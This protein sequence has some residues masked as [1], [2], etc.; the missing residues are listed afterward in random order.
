MTLSKEEEFQEAISKLSDEE[1]AALV[2]ETNEAMGSYKFVPNEGP[3]SDAYFSKADVTLFGGNPGGGKSALI[4]G[5]ANNE[6]HRS[7]IVRKNFSDLEGIMDNAKKILGTTKGFVG[8]SRPKYTK[9]DGGVMH[10]AGLA[11]DGGIGGHQGVD[12]DLLCVGR[13]T[14]VLMADGSYVCIE[15][16]SVGDM[17]DTLEGPR[18]I[19]KTFPVR[20]DYGVRVFSSTPA[21]QLQSLDHSLYSSCSGGSW[22]KA[23]S[24]A[25]SASTLYCAFYRLFGQ[26]FGLSPAPL[27]PL[28]VLLIY[29]ARKAEQGLRFLGNACLSQFFSCGE[30]SHQESGF[31]KYYGLRPRRLPPLLSSS[32]RAHQQPPLRSWLQRG[33]SSISLVR[34]VSGAVSVS[35]PQG[36]Q[37]SCLSGSCLC[38]GQPRSYPLP[39]RGLKGSLL[40]LL[41][42]IGV[43]R[44][45]PTYFACDCE[46]RTPKCTRRVGRYVHPYKMDTRPIYKPLVSCV[47]YY[48]PV[49]VIDLFDIEVEDANHYITRGGF[50]NKNCVDEAA[51]VPEDQV[52][53]LMTWLRTDKA[54]QRVRTVLASNPPLDSTGDWLVEYFAPW[55]DERH[56]N[57]AKAGELRYFLPAEDGVG[58]R[59]CDKDEIAMVHGI[60]VRPQSRTYIPSKFTDNPYYDPEEYAKQLAGMPDSYKEIL[61][62][63]NFMLNREDQDRQVIPTSWVR[64]ANARWT[65]AGRQKPM[66]IIAADVAGGGKDDNV[67]ARLHGQW[68][69]ELE[70]KSGKKLPESSDVAGFIISKRKNKAAIAIDMG[71]GYGSGPKLALSDSGASIL[72]YKGVKGTFGKNRDKSLGFTNVRSEAYWALRE[73]LDP[74]N[75]DR[76]CL[77]VD[78]RLLAE[79][80]AVRFKIVRY[81]GALCVQLEDKPTVKKN[82]GRSPDRADAVVIA[83]YLRNKAAK[84]KER[85]LSGKKS[86]LKV[87]LG[88][89]NRKKPRR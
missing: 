21:S 8:G 72:E 76:L 56:E 77:P 69:D 62:T 48:S 4:I 32:L 82:L 47:S 78:P 49:G 87:K 63:G 22:R 55:L 85:E 67:L 6:H 29:L 24:L 45:I 79:L 88:Y 80:T 33:Y 30:Q 84:M 25:L 13:G 10:F 73:A 53:L 2:K 16:L 23:G 70:T 14:E 71:G 1:Y 7:L 86:G 20:R 9:P 57:P 61:M 35:S 12:H 46:A 42:L 75:E 65:E 36:Y 66:D 40:Y 37:E 3:Q 19:T 58:D 26:I 39:A 43:E 51:T 41:R 28:L 81:L 68:F 11:D 83:W 44:P 27:R 89:T 64:E 60:E 17:V 34:D 31:L 38:G 5:L 59:E 52:R 54:G 15:D 74:D 50:V 18:K